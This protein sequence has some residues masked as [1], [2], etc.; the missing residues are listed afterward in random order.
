MRAGFDHRFPINDL[1]VCAALLDPSQRHLDIVQDYLTERET[2]G[3]QFLSSII[4][5]YCTGATADTAR[6]ATVGEP[7]ADDEPL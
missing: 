2:N 7:T 4:D 1:H 3:V 6:C 5:K